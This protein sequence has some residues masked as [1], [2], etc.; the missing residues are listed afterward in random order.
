MAEQQK[1]LPL[2]NL[3]LAYLNGQEHGGAPT[4][5]DVR[6]IRDSQYRCEQILKEA[7]DHAKTLHNDKDLE[8]CAQSIRSIR[9]FRTELEVLRE[10][11]RKPWVHILS[12]IDAA[13]VPIATQL[14]DLER[15]I[16]VEMA[17]WNEKKQEGVRREKEKL[18]AKAEEERQRAK[19][20]ED[21]IK[22]RAAH[23]AANQYKLEARIVAKPKSA[24]GVD[25]FTYFRYEI[26]NRPLAA[27]LPEE[28]I[29]LQLHYHWFEEERKKKEKLHQELIW[30]GIE[31]IRETRVK[32]H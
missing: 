32:V 2:T 18:E 30:P 16:K 6:L 11:E 7:R 25:T 28:A 4:F 29:S 14:I 1:T 12:Q 19:F 5:K 8:I 9:D 20:V 17:H 3:E 26:S 10:M 13:L 27:K 31:V 22:Q 23:A 15:A 24:K 21:P